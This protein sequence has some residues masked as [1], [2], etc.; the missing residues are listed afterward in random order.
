MTFSRCPFAHVRAWAVLISACLASCS[1]DEPRV[2]Q[3]NGTSLSV[4]ERCRFIT[5]ERGPFPVTFRL[6]NDGPQPLIVRWG[7]GC[8]WDFRISSCASSFTDALQPRDPCP[9][10]CEFSGCPSCGA[11]G[12][13]EEAIAPGR[14][15]DR[16]WEGGLLVEQ[17][18][19]QSTCLEPRTVPA[20]LYRLSLPVY[21]SSEDARRSAPLRTVV[22]DFSLPAAGAVVALDLDR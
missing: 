22:K 1:S 8:A 4:P 14:S 19:G 18:R 7:G 21:A 15:S 17:P 2:P 20:G 5:E 12:P 10:L 9:C 3:R 16:Q 11:C 6:R 13:E